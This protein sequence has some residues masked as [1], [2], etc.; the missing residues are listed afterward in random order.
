MGV[1]VT[2]ADVTYDTRRI[3][4]AVDNSEPSLRAVKLAFDLAG[5]CGAQLT[6]L[7]VVWLPIATQQEIA[8]YVQHEHI[9]DMPVA[10]VREAA[11]NDLYLLRDRVAMHSGVA[12]SCE[13]RAGEAATE[14]VASAREHAI[15]LIVV[16]HR[17]H[18][19]V[20]GV[21]LGSVA[22]SV[23]ELAPCPVLVVR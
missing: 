9:R 12:V 22:R 18:R 4:C 16:G 7:S 1:S 8:D 6:L 3:L 17:S 5:K 20:A 21:L 11:E 23:I 2:P 13:V 10:V 15:D 14:I 19:R